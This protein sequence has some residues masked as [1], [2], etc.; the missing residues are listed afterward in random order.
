MFAWK[1]NLEKIG[2]RPRGQKVMWSQPVTATQ[3]YIAYAGEPLQPGQIYQWVL[4]DNQDK[5]FAFAPFKM[6][7]AQERDRIKADLA[8]LD[9]ELKSKS[10]TLEQI[11][12][13]RANYFAQKGLWSDVLQEVHSVK[14][15]S[16]ELQAVLK[17][18]PDQL[19]STD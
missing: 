17:A 3:G 2:V 14:T 11:A 19:C 1:G 5:P 12:L 15:P 8:R 18:I 13:Q 10:A 16:G 9:E 7:D 4:L 6:M